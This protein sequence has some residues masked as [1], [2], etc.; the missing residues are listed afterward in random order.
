M[1]DSTARLAD[2]TLQQRHDEAVRV[3]R[4]HPNI[5]PEL[6]SYVIWPTEAPHLAEIDALVRFQI[7]KRQREL[8]CAAA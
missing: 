3:L 6:L 4:D 8:N 7:R 5:G 2:S 1:T